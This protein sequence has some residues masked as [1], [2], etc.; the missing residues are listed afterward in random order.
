[1]RST[2]ISSRR[3]TGVALIATIAGLALAPAAHAGTIVAP[4]RADGLG[5]ANYTPH[6]L[7]VTPPDRA[8]RLGGAVSGSTIVALPPDRQD[9][10]GSARFTQSAVPTVIVRSA[11]SGFDWTSALIGAVAGLGIALAAAAALMARGRGDV[12]LPS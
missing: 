7:A 9:G 2:H 4:D 6:R 10:L 12:A 3:R 5:G 11:N 1:M 8:D